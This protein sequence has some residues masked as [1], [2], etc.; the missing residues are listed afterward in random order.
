M[1]VN[2]VVSGLVGGEDIEATPKEVVANPGE[3]VTFMCK[4]SVKHL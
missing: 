1:P 4:V 3:N 2:V